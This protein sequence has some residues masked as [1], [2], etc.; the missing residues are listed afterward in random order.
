M[1]AL[2]TQALVTSAMVDARLMP[3]APDRLS[4]DFGRP[5]SF[6]RLVAFQCELQLTFIHQRGALNAIPDCVARLPN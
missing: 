6:V 4:P 1:G 2:V 3:C 5:F